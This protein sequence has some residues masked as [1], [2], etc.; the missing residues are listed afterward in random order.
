MKNKI[1]CEEILEEILGKGVIDVENYILCVKALEE[2]SKRSWNLA[3]ELI[4]DNSLVEYDDDEYD[5]GMRKIS[6]N[7]FRAVKKSS[8]KYIK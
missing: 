5:D 6:C 3:F 4:E 1:D 7:L 8:N 2:A